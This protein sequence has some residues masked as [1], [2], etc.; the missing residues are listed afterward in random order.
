MNVRVRLTP[1][2]TKARIMTV[3][4][5]LFRRIGYAKTAVADIAAELGMS[6]ANVYRFFPSKGAINNAIC[7][8]LC[9][10]GEARVEALAAA[11]MSA[12]EKLRSAILCMHEYNKAL[13]TSEKRIHE[14]VAAAMEEN[15]DS[16]EAHCDRCK[17]VIARIVAE[18]VASGEFDPSLDSET[19]GK[20]IFG[21]CAGFFHPTLIAQCA[22]KQDKP[23]PHAMVDF[24]LRALRNSA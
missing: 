1:E 3:A 9:A 18:G 11:P 2:E 15:W 7:Q 13:L 23:D 6:P 21:A 20:A 8:R 10:E 17:D 5:E 14:M 16:I 22:R 19:C 12:T 4:E 24:I